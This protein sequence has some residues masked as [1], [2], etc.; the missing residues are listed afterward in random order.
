M[1]EESKWSD[2]KNVNMKK[3]LASNCNYFWLTPS[4]EC[5]ISIQNWWGRRED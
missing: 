2:E 5:V 4:K 1:E 3:K